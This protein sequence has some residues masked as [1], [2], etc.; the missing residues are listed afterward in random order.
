LALYDGDGHALRN[1]PAGPLT[2]GELYEQLLVG[3]A[4]REVGKAYAN[5][6][7]RGLEVL[8]EQELSRLAVVAFAMLNRSAQWVTEEAVGADL[9]VTLG[10][11][12]PVRPPS[13]SAGALTES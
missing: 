1:G 12:A 11:S 5:V 6:S 9:R 3:F 13:V 7:A 4:R 8:V 2:T 10:D